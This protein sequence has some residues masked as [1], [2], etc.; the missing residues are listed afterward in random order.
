MYGS[1]DAIKTAINLVFPLQR[2]ICDDYRKADYVII[3][4]SE[5]GQIKNCDIKGKLIT[6]QDN[7]YNNMDRFDVWEAAEYIMENL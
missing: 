1:N 3:Y 7:L 4:E 5:S 2:Q 6:L